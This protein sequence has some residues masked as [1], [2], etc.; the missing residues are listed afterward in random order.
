MK[1]LVSVLAVS[2]TLTG[3]FFNKEKT[4]EAPAHEEQA[5][6][7]EAKNDN[8]PEPAAATETTE[9]AMQKTESGIE[10]KVIQAGKSEQHPQAGQTVTVHYT[11]YLDDN[12]K[13]GQK[14][15]SSVDRNQQFSFT[16]GVGQVIKGWDE[17]VLA[18]TPGEKR[19]VTI[20]A[21][22]AYGEQGAGGLIPPHAKLNFEIELI[23]IK[24]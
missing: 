14:F 18:M 8:A 3:C 1:T 10:Y 9:V 11:G 24:S 16:V 4:M 20:P 15:D 22:L 12:G 13:R 23:D 2:C 17:T 6:Q 5:P 7:E 19:E 21:E